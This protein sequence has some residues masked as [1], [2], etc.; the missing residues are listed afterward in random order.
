VIDSER[1]RRELERILADQTHE[2]RDLGGRVANDVWER[3]RS[4]QDA[5]QAVA[6]ALD[7]AGVEDAL[8]TRLGRDVVQS[9]LAGAGIMP[10]IGLTAAAIDQFAAK[11]LTM[12]WDSSGLSLSTRLHG[13][14]G[15]VEADVRHAVA[16]AI[17][18]R[19]TAWR[20]AR[21]I[22]DGY[23]FGGALKSRD[24][25]DLPRDLRQLV[26]VTRLALVPADSEFVRREVAKLRTYAEALRTGPLRAGY[27]QLVDRLEAG[28]GRGL[29]NAVRVATEEKARY[30]AERIMRTETASA[31]GQGFL[32]QL[33]DDPDAVGLE[34]S[35]SSAHQVFDICDFHSR[36]NLFGMGRGVY[37]KDRAPRYPAHPHCLCQLSAVYTAPAPRDQVDAGGR[38][39]LNGMTDA[40]QARLLTWTGK[41]AFDGSG[42]WQGS[43]R[44][45]QAPGR[46]RLSPGASAI[47][48]GAKDVAVRPPT[49][50]ANGFV[51]DAALAVV[52]QERS[53]WKNR[54]ETGIILKEGERVTTRKG[55]ARTVSFDFSDL[56]KMHG[57]VVTHNHPGGWDAPHGDEYRAGN[58]FS[59][60]DLSLASRGMVRQMR[61]VTPKWVYS[62][63]PQG[64]FKAK[65]EIEAQFSDAREFMDQRF[66]GPV[67]KSDYF[68]AINEI[69]AEIFGWK[70]SREAHGFD[71]T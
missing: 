10:E 26:D 53:I 31:W 15:T 71:R 67:R 17:S 54:F 28:L 9:L 3:V 14:V 46:A 23:G 40:Q 24:L 19:D 22:Y 25:S 64:R 39:A 12:S 50:M 29:E 33:Q 44:Q 61:A 6:A 52:E 34:W 21:R 16:Q 37:P 47:I 36:A 1:A 4:G 51:T 59:S 49:G 7:A 70:Y 60:A 32:H 18:R 42:A 55:T 41:Q 48:S 5:S 20:T 11:A 30:F 63:E 27:R 8:R 43:L 45:W 2:V 62:I 66:I 13:A 35:T 57:A 68:H 56:V 65:S 38:A 58:S 69:V